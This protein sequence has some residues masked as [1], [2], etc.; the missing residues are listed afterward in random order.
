YTFTP[1]GPSVDATG[2]VSGMTVGTSYTVIADNGSCSSIASASFSNALMLVSPVQPTISSVAPT[3]SADGSSS[4]S[5]YDATLSYTFT[6]AGPSVDATGLVSGMTVGTSYTV[7]SNNGNCDS[8]ASA[9]FSNAAMLITP[10]QPT[11]SSVAPTCLADGTSTISNYDATLSYTFTPSGPSVDATGL[12]SGMTVGTSYTVI[13]D[14]GSCSSIASASF[15]NALMLVSPVLVIT[16]PDPVCFS[17]P[18]DLTAAAVTAGSTIGGV[19]S[20]WNDAAATVALAN[21]SAITTG[22]T[23]YIQSTLG[24]CSDIEPVV[25]TMLPLANATISSNTVCLG[26]SGTVSFF[27]TPNATVTY[28]VDS[29]MSQTI[30]LN[31]TGNASLTT[32]AL[33]ANSIYTIVDVSISYG[34]LVCNNPISASTTVVVTIP[35]TAFTTTVSSAFSENSV[36]VVNVQD[37]NGTFLYQIDDEGFQTSN[38]FT[39]VSAGTHTITVTDTQGCTYVIGSVFLIDYPKFF[40]PNGDGYND[41]WKITGLN[42]PDAVL[43]IFDRYGKLVKQLSVM[44]TAQGWDGTFNGEQLPSTDYWFTLDFD[45][46]TQRRQ[47]KSH[48]S[49]KR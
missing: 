10:V 27:G 22:G 9:S 8:A 38:I 18:V 33:M 35:A 7:I 31:A 36:V 44:D 26:T 46:G 42:Q 41:T 16:D 21:P 17:T 25:I 14:N 1:S 39:G 5:N 15:S 32:P 43:Y 13:A 2:L 45:E 11:I 47:F 34:G 28:V 20:Y 40:T 23:Y 29:G 48:F 37:G 30:L 4:I 24:S 49:L 3:C 6:P 12:V 19:L